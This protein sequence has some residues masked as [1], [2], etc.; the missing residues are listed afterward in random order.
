MNDTGSRS[1]SGAS[2]EGG[3]GTLSGPAILAVLAVIA[4]VCTGGYF[5]LLKMIDVSQQDDCILAHRR[6]CASGAIP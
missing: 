4:L 6:D 2:P 3:S 1:R 5:F